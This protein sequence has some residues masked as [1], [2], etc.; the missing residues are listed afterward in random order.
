[1]GTIVMSAFVA[2]TAW[3]WMLDR[4]E[5]LGW[6]FIMAILGA[7]ALYFVSMFEPMGGSA[8]KYTGMNV[9][10][11]LAAINASHQSW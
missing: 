8:P 6:G 1:M 4:G 3:H 2:H 9:I 11:P 7:I 5:A 10:N